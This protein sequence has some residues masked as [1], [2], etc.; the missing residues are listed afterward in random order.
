MSGEPTRR[1]GPPAGR[2][3]AA[4][5]P[6]LSLP[7]ALSREWRVLAPLEAHGGEAELL[8]V[9]RSAGGELAVAKLYRPGLRARSAALESLPAALADAVVRVLACGQSDGLACEIL[10]YCRFG[11]LRTLIEDRAADR[12]WLREVLVQLSGALAALHGAGIVHGRL[13]PENVLVRSLHPLKLVLADFALADAG[14]APPAFASI[15]RAVRYAPPEALSGAAT[16]GADYWS[17][18]LILLEMYSGRH[19]FAALSE[20]AIRHQLM[21]G[22]LDLSSVSDAAWRGLL[23]GLL[24]RHPSRRWGA[25][26]IRGWLEGIPAL[27]TPADDDGVFVD[28][29]RP[30]VFAEARY[31]RPADLAQA[32]V[33]HWQAGARDLARGFVTAW[34]RDEAGDQ[35]LARHVMELMDDPS[36]TPDLRLLRFAL[37]AAPKLPAVWRGQPLT[38]EGLTAVVRAALA[39]QSSERDLLAD[40]YEQ[41]VLLMFPAGHP[42]SARLAAL[43]ERWR[44]RADICQQV[45]LR[46]S[47]DEQEGRRAVAAISGYADVDELLYGGARDLQ[48]MTGVLPHA[49]LLAPEYVPEEVQCARE[50]VAAALA[51]ECSWFRAG[52][53]PSRLGIEELAALDSVLPRV[54]RFAAEARARQ[55]RRE[56]AAAAEAAALRGEV[57]AMLQTARAFA[58][59]SG[60]VLHLRA[61]LQGVYETYQRL[62]ARAHAESAA[63]ANFEPVRRALARTGPRL[64]HMIEGID[65][66][67]YLGRLRGLVLYQGWPFVLAVLL[68]P[69]VARLPALLGFEV[70][71]AVAAIGWYALERTFV[72]DRIRRYAARLP[73]SVEESLSAPA[74]AD[75]QAAPLP[76]A[77]PGG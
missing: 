17:L 44:R 57:D 59:G 53:D 5:R 56:E 22:P 34:L 7:R 47:A 45:Q 1:D 77:L 55:A 11:S 66:L 42:D 3:A 67:D 6:A 38:D 64:V 68:L 76:G 58:Q 13:K 30:Y 23:R 41:D 46:L 43:R 51:A 27:D 65:R 74:S 52:D 54:R 37:R 48:R 14:S 26:D 16:P 21:A 20:A 32:L 60:S 36:L 24:A 61:G 50:R 18:G 29:V 8:M 73:S 70:V 71:V 35:G 31:T 33:S 28:P 12:R 4:E 63:H 10:E 19:P 15:D 2:P 75:S 39:G 69:V 25:Q 9:A 40:L 62:F 49:L 72:L